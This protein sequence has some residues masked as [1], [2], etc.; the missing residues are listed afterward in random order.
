MNFLYALL[1][2][3]VLPLMYFQLRNETKPKKNIVLG[4]TIP[5]SALQSEKLQSITH[6]YKRALLRFLIC[7]HIPLIPLFFT[8]KVSFVFGGMM[9][10]LT[11]VMAVGFGIYFRYHNRIRLWKQTQGWDSKES[12]AGAPVCVDVEA[13][14]KGA[15]IL[16]FWSYLPALLISLA[17]PVYDFIA[18]PQ[19]ADRWPMLLGS[20][21]LTF[22]IAVLMLLDLILRRRSEAVNDDS[23]LNAALT[24]ARRGH[25]CRCCLWCSY[26]TALQGPVL[27]LMTRGTISEL[28]GMACICLYVFAL[29][30]VAIRAEFA[31]RHAQERLAGSVQNVTDTDGQWPLGMFYFN[32]EDKRLLVHNR[33]GTNST[34]NI[35]RPAGKVIMALSVLCILMLPF[36]SVLLI[37]EE[38]SPVVVTLEEDTLLISHAAT[39][40]SIPLEQIEDAALLETLPRSFRVAGTGL[41][42]LLKGKFTMQGY[43]QSCWFCLNPKNG[44]FLTFMYGDTRYVLNYSPACAP[45]LENS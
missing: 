35:A 19:A 11:A 25:W 22:V 31:C 40:K 30:F 23:A 17:L 10:W 42:T 28:W 44:P 39:K 1:V 33:V 15:P 14:A 9:L 36:V 2:Y 5:Y 43:A 24:Q 34:F 27:F 12:S 37:S 26:L 8:S 21:S 18:E 45:L 6:S 4:V 16:S 29:L 20:L 3:P 7:V 32:P 41:P 38:T 13:I